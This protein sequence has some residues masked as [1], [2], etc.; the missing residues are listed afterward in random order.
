MQAVLKYLFIQE[1]FE[2]H[3][4]QGLK[5]T[6]ARLDWI[7]RWEDLELEERKTV[8]RLPVYLKDWEDSINEFGGVNAA[9]DFNRKKQ[10]TDPLIDLLVTVQ[11]RIVKKHNLNR[12]TL[13]KRIPKTGEIRVLICAA[14]PANLER[15]FS[16]YEIGEI[17][18][19]QLTENALERLKIRPLLGTTLISFK[20]AIANFNPHIVHFAG[21]GDRTGIYVLNEKNKNSRRVP[22]KTLRRIFDASDSV[23]CVV[24]SSCYSE[25]QAKEISN[26]GLT[27]VGSLKKHKAGAAVLFAKYFY[28]EIGNGKSIEDA[29]AVTEMGFYEDQKFNFSDIKI[30]Y[31]T[32]RVD[33]PE[34]SDLGSIKSW[35]KE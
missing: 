26:S 17:L 25:S 10:L 28:T 35:T 3:R 24:L 1:L 16:E 5:A 14:S 7:T 9:G 34:E 29:L 30:Y 31:P 18:N 2:I 21:H 15:T 20:Q 22:A 11:E 23:V 19:K 33:V 27:V 8:L 6:L 32:F 13:A 4:N 12:T